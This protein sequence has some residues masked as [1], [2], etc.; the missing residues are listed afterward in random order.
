MKHFKLQKIKLKNILHTYNVRFCLT[1][2]AWT[3]Q[4]KIG[5]LTLP[6]HYIDSE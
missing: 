2:N 4:I 6:A 5:F 3:S 1:S